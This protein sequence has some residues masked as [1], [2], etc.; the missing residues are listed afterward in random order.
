MRSTLFFVFL[1]SA[2]NVGAAEEYS[3]WIDPCTPSLTK[4]TACEP[5]DVKLGEW[6]LEAWQ[7][8]SNNAIA[9][10]KSQTE[11]HA[12]IRIHWAGGTDSLYGET[13]PALVDGRRGANIYVL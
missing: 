8:E 10:K 6:A 3:W 5:D 7:R 2:A 11:E 12:R 1:L 4:S 13:Q 9:L